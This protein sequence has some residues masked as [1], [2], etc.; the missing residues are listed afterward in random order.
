MVP[1]TMEDKLMD[2]AGNCNE[3]DD[4]SDSSEDENGKVKD[5][6]ADLM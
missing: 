2:G 5:S 1:A 6:P 3:S 4:D